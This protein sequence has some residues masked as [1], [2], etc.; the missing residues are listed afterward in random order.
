MHCV[1]V[2]PYTV[3]VLR[4]TICD[5]FVYIKNVGHSLLYLPIIQTTE[6]GKPSKPNKPRK[7]HVW[8]IV[9]LYT[10]NRLGAFQ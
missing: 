3:P 8:S 10:T 6:I 5:I 7:C 9:L 4:W 2:W 1:C